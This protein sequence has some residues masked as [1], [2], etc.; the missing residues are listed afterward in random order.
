MTTQKLF[1]RRIRERMTKSG[2]SYTAARL[3][4]VPARDR[5]AAARTNLASAKELASDEKLTEATGQDWD[6]WLAILDGWGARDRAHREIAEYLVAEHSVPSWWVQAVTTGY[7]R[8]RGLRLKHQ[9]PDG[10]TVYASKTVGAP[11]G[12]LF[13]AVVDQ[14]TREQWLTDGT[15][16][17]RTSQPGKAARFDWGD[18]ATRVLVTFEEKGPM[19]ATAHVSHERLPGADAA[20]IAK[21]LWKKRVAALKG[22]L[23]S[24]DV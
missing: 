1:K 21:A 3:H 10:F 5:V 8:A 4:V 18:G 16:T 19:K 22:F 2:E 15:M 14:R 12:V 7:E 24:T 13:D 9:Q 11:I 23:E 6:G 17:L 20:E